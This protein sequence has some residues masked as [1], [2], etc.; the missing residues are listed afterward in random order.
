M[1]NMNK[2]TIEGFVMQVT[3][4]DKYGNQRG[5]IEVTRASGVVDKVPFICKGDSLKNGCWI[6]VE[7]IVQTRNKKDENGN[8]HKS[9]FV[10]VQK[11]VELTFTCRNEVLIE[12]YLVKKDKLRET[13]SGKTIMD[14]VLAINEDRKSYYPSIIGWYQNAFHLNQM[15]IGTKVRLKARFQSREYIKRTSES[16]QVKTAYELS[17][18]EIE[19][20]EE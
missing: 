8:S 19:E 15:E 4:V 9:M 18:S 14:A 20:V 6:A 2:V 5:F 12:G 1:N 11:A 13:P 7:G 16:E 10:R 17:V 3:P